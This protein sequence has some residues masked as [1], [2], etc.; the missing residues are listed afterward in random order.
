MPIIDKDAEGHH[1]SAPRTGVAYRSQLVNVE[2]F[3]L[4]A[5]T[6]KTILAATQV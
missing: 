3:V 2:G 6:W 1:G 5:H 4:L